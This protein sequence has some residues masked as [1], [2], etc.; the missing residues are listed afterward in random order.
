MAT[1]KQLR[2]LSAKALAKHHSYERRIKALLEKRKETCPHIK[3]RVVRQDYM[4]E[5][6]MRSPIEWEE[7]LCCRCKKVLATRG[8]NV[9]KSEW[10]AKEGINLEAV[11]VKGT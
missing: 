10:Q 4:E 9:V 2:E 3:T 1:L 8:D 6:R 11:L 7:L 5:G